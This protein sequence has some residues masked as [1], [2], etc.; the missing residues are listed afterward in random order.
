MPT[1]T[2]RAQS[3]PTQRLLI[4]P[5]VIAVVVSAVTGFLSGRPA[6]YVLS[7]FYGAAAFIVPLA[8]RRAMA[9]IPALPFY[10]ILTGALMVP[11]G[12]LL[13]PAGSSSDGAVAISGRG[14]LLLLGLLFL[15]AGVIQALR[16]SRGRA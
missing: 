13:P 14:P 1:E 5:V 6:F 8:A 15:L 16:G 11:F 3:E 2:P 7:A 4:P 12:A 9:R 10:F